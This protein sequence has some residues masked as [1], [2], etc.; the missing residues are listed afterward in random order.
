VVVVEV[1]EVVEVIVV[2]VLVVAVLWRLNGIARV[3]FVRAV[4]GP[5]NRN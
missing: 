3:R 1:V 5:L 2:R 4:N